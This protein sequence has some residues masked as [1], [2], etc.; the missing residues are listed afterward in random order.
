MKR[1]AFLALLLCACFVAASAG[2]SKQHQSVRVVALH[3]PAGGKPMSV[4]F[5][6]ETREMKPPLRFHW[7]FGNGREWNGAE[8][9]PQHFDGGRYDVIVA[10]TD[11]DGLV[12][13]TSLTI[14]VE[15][16]HEH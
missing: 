16:E 7:S 1:F 14:D 13:T 8:P 10:V 15:G 12:S 11:A 5:R 3:D 9:P 4:T 6:A 2:Q